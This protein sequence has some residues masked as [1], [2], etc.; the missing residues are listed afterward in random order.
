MYLGDSPSGDRTGPG[1]QLV[2]PRRDRY[3]KGPAEGSEGLH[4]RSN[5]VLSA[6]FAQGC[7]T[8]PDLGSFWLD[9]SAA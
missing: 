5:P 4:P 6:A 2:Q 3:S 7:E 8:D 9:L 1:G